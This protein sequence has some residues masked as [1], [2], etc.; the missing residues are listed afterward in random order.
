M[1]SLMP[2]YTIPN[3]SVKEIVQYLG[4]NGFNI[5]D[6]DILLPNSGYVCKLYEGVLGVF[7]EERIA[8]GVEESVGIVQIFGRM[9]HLM[10]RLGFGVF[11]MKDITQ[12]ESARLIKILSTVINFGLF[13]ESKRHVY[14]SIYRKR[15][16][17]EGAV[18]ECE[19]E[20][21]EQKERLRKKRQERDAAQKQIKMLAK[22]VANQESEIVNF[23]RNQQALVN[24]IEEIK[25][26]HSSLL[27][28]INV[29]KCQL[30]E[31]KQEV[32]RLQAKIVKN[33]EQLKELLMGMKMQLHNEESILREYE[34]KISHLH[35]NIGQFKVAVEDLKSL[36]CTVSL[37]GEYKTR[38]DDGQCV[39]KQLQSSNTNLEI[40]NNS[41]EAEK[42][43]LDR[44][45]SYIIEK[46]NALTLEDTARI[47]ST[48]K[49]FE[50][51]REKHS[52]II[53]ERESAQALIQKNNQLI[54][55]LENEIVNVE[56][57]HE[58]YLSSV[59]TELLQ[60]KS[61][62]AGYATDLDMVFKGEYAQ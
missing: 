4:D 49:E 51:L 15:E 46:M 18:E 5:L 37:T 25:R 53:A 6:S 39:L 31:A 47:E 60:Q 20:A 40:E 56:A 9:R 13:K 16:E 3:M 52:T 59:Y 61:F 12:P 54:K 8:E 24:Q 26:E 28:R 34:K 48:R 43:L 50:A 36:V 29:E 41:K 57:K 19:Q 30:I 10:E 32:S 17:I 55:E 1:K 7:A 27:E 23:H 14:S 62:L 45:I 35:K 11:Q 22:E 38:L 21:R 42:N 44:K 33:P 2:T 58:S